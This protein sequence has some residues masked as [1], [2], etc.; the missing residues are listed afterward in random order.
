[1]DVIIE[2]FYSVKEASEIFIRAGLNMQPDTLR[3]K[4]RGAKIGYYRHG[5]RPVFT[6]EN[7]EQYIK[8]IKVL[9]QKRIRP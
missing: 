9:P 8:Q 3:R 6:I 2:K 7:I 4:C 1:M 5:N